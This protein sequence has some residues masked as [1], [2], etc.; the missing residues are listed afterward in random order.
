MK[1]AAVLL[2]AALL[3]GCATSAQRKPAATPAAPNVSTDG[4]AVAATTGAADDLDMYAATGD[5][6]DPIEPVNRGIFWANHQLYRYVLKPVSKGY[7][8]VVPKKGREAIYN[9]FE[10]IKFPQRF[11]NNLLQGNPYRATQETGRFLVNTTFGLGGLGK[12]A[13]HV[14]FLADVPNA[15]TAQTFAKWGVPNGFYFV[16]P[17]MGPTTLRD[18]VGLAGDYCMNPITWAGF[19]WGGA[20]WFVAVPAGNTMR[21]LP[22]QMATYDAATKDSIDRYLAARTAYIQYRNEV[23]A[24]ALQGKKQD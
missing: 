9:A 12:P 22:Y 13:D 1:T 2:A 3:A 8:F 16:I 24:R 17:V 6:P 11:V 19:I 21:A 20:A 4:K 7:E 18:G 10:N 14:V 5:V 23:N 15:D